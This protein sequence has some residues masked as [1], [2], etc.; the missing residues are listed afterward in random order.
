MGPAEPLSP[1]LWT[2]LP[3]CEVK[4]ENSL[5]FPSVCLPSSSFMLDPAQ[6]CLCR[7]WGNV[8]HLQTFTVHSPASWAVVGVQANARYCSFLQ[9]QDALLLHPVSE[10]PSKEQQCLTGE[11][12]VVLCREGSAA[13]GLS[14]A[15]ECQIGLELPEVWHSLVGKLSDQRLQSRRALSVLCQPFRN[16]SAEIGVRSSC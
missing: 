3:L 12:S 10:H 1:S 14:Q 4:E 6:R 13:R 15:H 2:S 16:S 11:F 7:I 5:S 9:I 8:L